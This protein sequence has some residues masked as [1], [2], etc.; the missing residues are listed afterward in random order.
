MFPIASPI[1]TYVPTY[2]FSSFD[3]AKRHHLIT[4]QDHHSKNGYT[5][6]PSPIRKYY[7]IRITWLH[8]YKHIYI[9]RSFLGAAPYIV[10]IY[11][12]CCMVS[13]Y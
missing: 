6:R 3:V 12:L 5:R 4:K 13:C 1:T 9:Y 2:T 7:Q 10:F 8:I 11:R